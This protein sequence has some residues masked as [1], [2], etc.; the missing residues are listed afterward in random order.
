MWICIFKSFCF[1]DYWLLCYW[2]CYKVVNYCTIKCIHVPNLSEY[3]WILDIN[4]NCKPI[5]KWLPKVTDVSIHFKVCRCKKLC[6]KYCGSG[7][8]FFTERCGCKKI[9]KLNTNSPI[10]NLIV[11]K[12]P[13]LIFS[14]IL[15]LPLSSRLNNTA[16]NNHSDIKF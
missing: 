11:F 5:W 10:C 15:N 6:L 16:V 9:N 3:E 8:L 14:F 2:G 12:L 4:E 1:W 7:N 13:F